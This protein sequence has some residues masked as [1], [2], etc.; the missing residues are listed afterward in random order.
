MGFIPFKYSFQ[1]K[2]TGDAFVFVLGRFIACLFHDQPLT[3]K[4]STVYLCAYTMSSP[5]DC[6]S[7]K[8][9]IDVEHAVFASATHVLSVEFDSD[10]SANYYRTDDLGA[11]QLKEQL[12]NTCINNYYIVKVAWDCDLPLTS[13]TPRVICKPDS[14]S[15][16]ITTKTPASQKT[17]EKNRCVDCGVPLMEGNMEIYVEFSSPLDEAMC[18]DCGKKRLKSDKKRAKKSPAAIPLCYLTC[19]IPIAL[20]CIDERQGDLKLARADF[21]ESDELSDTQTAFIGSAFDT[22][23]Q[24]YEDSI[25]PWAYKN[26]GTKKKK[27]TQ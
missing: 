27:S 6:V 25:L 5:T 2:K 3:C 19:M 7:F 12:N 1:K 20:K 13:L 10:A 15:I 18:L 21:D 24:L 4:N 26:G 8:V 16:P 22:A 14:V 23:A 17:K 9:R 11:E